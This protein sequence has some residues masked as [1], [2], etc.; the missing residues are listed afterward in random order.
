MGLRNSSSTEGAI[1]PTYTRVCGFSGIDGRTM[2]LGRINGALTKRLGAR[3]GKVG[4]L[5]IGIKGTP[6]N[7]GDMPA[8]AE[9]R[10]GWK[11]KMEIK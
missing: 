3:G 5:S 11:T 1:F 4:G 2:A 8:G 10:T 7:R 6:G 9:P